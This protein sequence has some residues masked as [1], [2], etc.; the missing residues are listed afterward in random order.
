MKLI[1]K[2]LDKIF[3]FADY[4]QRERCDVRTEYNIIMVSDLNGCE[5]DMYCNVRIWHRLHETKYDDMYYARPTIKFVTKPHARIQDAV[6][7]HDFMI[8]DELLT[9]EFRKKHEITVVMEC[10]ELHP[11]YF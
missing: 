5:P 2:I 3:N 10:T 8:I 9:D 6:N 11:E 4:M 7:D 1:Q